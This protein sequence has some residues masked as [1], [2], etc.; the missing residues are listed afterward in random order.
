MTIDQ[1]TLQNGSNALSLLLNGR[2]E[3][4][5][6]LLEMNGEVAEDDEPADSVAAPGACVEC[7]GK[8]IPQ[9]STSF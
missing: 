8:L 4:A 9:T 7:E 3:E 2:D 5:S 6:K 1:S